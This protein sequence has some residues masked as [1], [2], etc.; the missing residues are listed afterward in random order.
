VRTVLN[1]SE[2]IFRRNVTLRK[3]EI[4]EM[5]IYVANETKHDK[6]CCIVLNIRYI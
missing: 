1:F 6:I 3:L 5:K 2:R 4:K